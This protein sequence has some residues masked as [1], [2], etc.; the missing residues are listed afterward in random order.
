MDEPGE[1]SA[2]GPAT[3]VSESRIGQFARWALASLLFVASFSVPMLWGLHHVG[4]FYKSGESASPR[5]ELVPVATSF[6]G[7][8]TYL[9]VSNSPVLNPNAGHD[10]F[11]VV[12]MSLRRYPDPG[13][14]LIVFSKYD[15]APRPLNGYGF[16]LQDASEGVRPSVFWGDGGNDARWFDFSDI[17][18]PLKS[19]TVFIIGLHDDRYL[20][21]H[22]GVEQDGRVRGLQLLGGYDLGRVTLPTS[23]VSLVL[24]SAVERN[25][26]GS[27]GPFGIFSG[28][29]L[30]ESFEEWV[31]SALERVD[32]FEK[33]VPERTVKLW[34]PAGREDISRNRLTVELVTPDRSPGN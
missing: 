26:R 7:R 28:A 11:F 20:S 6:N 9:R 29:K 24:G 32:Q 31:A 27:I 22:G 21:L 14:R 30:S 15:G 16:A 33:A 13:E 19:W 18:Q 17:A 8:G 34:V 4:F 5:I 12:W 1:T 2:A 10:F 25:F 3:V 23:Q